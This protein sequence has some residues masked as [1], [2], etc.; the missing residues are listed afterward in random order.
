MM[1]AAFLKVPQLVLSEDES[2]K[3][4]EA[5]TSVTELYDIPLMDEKT[6]VWVNLAM[7]AGSIYGPRIVAHTLEKKASKP[8]PVVNRPLQVVQ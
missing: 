5:I 8:V 6:Q 3:L 4:A 7:V 1:G 2:K